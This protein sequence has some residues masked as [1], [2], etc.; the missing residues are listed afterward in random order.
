MNNKV[1]SAS[2][3]AWRILGGEAYPPQ[4]PHAPAPAGPCWLCGGDTDGDGWQR[5]LWL[6]PTFTNHNL[7]A[8]ITSPTIC[9]SCVALASKDT[10][11][12]Y[13]LSHPEMGLKTGHATRR[14]T[15]P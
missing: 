4:P 11:E 15:P 14:P 5:D 2:Q 6:T 13:V 10:W 3:F 12:R 8:C 9:Q 7:A 1:V